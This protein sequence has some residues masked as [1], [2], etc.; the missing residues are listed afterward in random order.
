MNCMTAVRWHHPQRVRLSTGTHGFYKWAEI[1]LCQAAHLESLRL[2]LRGARL[3]VHRVVNELGVV[4]Q[5]LQGADGRQHAGGLAAQQP[6]R[7]VGLEEVVV[8][9][10]L[11]GRQPAA[12]N[13]R[14]ATVA[15]MKI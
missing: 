15:C 13:L 7:R 12:H 3:G 1:R 5:L 6:P 8:Q 9:R 14:D 10:L 11:Q 4:A 2:P